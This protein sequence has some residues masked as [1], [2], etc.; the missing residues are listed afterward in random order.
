M[1]EW[2]WWWE[3]KVELALWK[4]LNSLTPEERQS[5]KYREICQEKVNL[6]GNIY[7]FKPFPAQ[8]PV[9]KD[10]NSLIFIHGNNSSGK[11]YCAAAYTA[12]EVIGWSPYRPVKPAKYGQKRIW[13][14]SPS[15]DIQRSS[16]QVHL[17]STDSPN[18][19]GL[20]PKL[21]VIE[22]YGGKVIWAGKK[23]LDMVEFPG[24]QV[25][26]EF[27]SAE[28]RMLNISA[29]GVDFV[30]LDECPPAHIYD[31]CWARVIRKDGRMIMSFLVED[32]QSN[33][34]VNDLYPSYLEE[35]REHGKS[36]KSFYFFTIEDN[37]ALNP[38]EIETKKNQFRTSSRLWRFSEGGMFYVAPKGMRVYSNFSPDIHVKDNLLEQ[39]D[40]LR[41][42]WRFWDLG[43]ERPA[44]LWVQVDRWG[45][46]R[47][48]Y[49][50]MGYQRQLTDYI[51]DMNDELRRL[52]PEIYN[53]VEVLPHDAKR[54]YDVSP[55]SSEDIF[56][57][58]RPKLQTECIYVKSEVAVDLAN[59]RL[60]LLRDGEPL[61]QIDSKYCTLL[62]QCLELYT[63]NED[64][65]LRHDDYYSHISDCFK[66]SIFYLCGF[67]YDRVPNTKEVENAKV[68][69]YFNL[70][71]EKKENARDTRERYF[72]L[73]QVHM[74]RS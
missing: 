8:L 40:K 53:V 25:V 52:I 51:D 9:H 11:S 33:Y 44:C 7:F 59:D 17:F 36:N 58:K 35:I 2:R 65:S 13:A 34:V 63:R 46:F 29:S 14:F 23:I 22:E 70:L 48:L 21:S 54:R 24:G 45:R 15:F 32:A 72:R 56:L 37:L 57:A 27:K 28:Q 42:L 18:D 5:P 4:K 3:D 61:I 49:A 74:E 10:I 16:S 55:L 19:I 39:V 67:G 71:E 41:T 60:R 6:Y 50:H 62:I 1:S 31:E 64:G 69:K 68:P 43:R 38:D 73:F 30:W 20:L 26:L 12:Y 47:Y 66:M